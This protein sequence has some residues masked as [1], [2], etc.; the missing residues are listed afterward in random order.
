MK[1]TFITFAGLMACIAMLF[2]ACSDTEN[3][4]SQMNDVSVST[5][6][7]V[8]EMLTIHYNGNTYENVPTTY[9]ENGDFVFHDKVFAPI[10]NQEL[11]N[12]SNL[13]IN[14]K[15]DNEIALFK[16]L[17]SNLEA[18]GYKYEECMKSLDNTNSQYSTSRI[19]YDYLAAVELFDDKDYGAPVKKFELT[20]QVISVEERRMHYIDFND[21]CSSLKIYNNIP[22]DSTKTILLG[23]YEYV[24]SKVDA[25]FFGYE[26]KDYAKKTI[27]YIATAGSYRFAQSLPGFNDKMSSFRFLFAQNGQYQEQ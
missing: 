22:N 9:D 25:V 3:L 10:Y 12:D 19:G 8:P 18:S 20:S 26:N 5:R 7:E 6:S 27:I 14:V 21:K 17:K 16:D 15:S 24:C 1:S 13:S 11:A 23:D 2:A 4:E